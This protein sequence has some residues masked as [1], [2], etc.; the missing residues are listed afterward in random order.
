[1]NQNLVLKDPVAADRL[2]QLVHGDLD[3]LVVENLSVVKSEAA[4]S[5]AVE[6]WVESDAKLMVLMVDMSMN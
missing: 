2:R 4:L 1:M 6:A 3:A 5:S